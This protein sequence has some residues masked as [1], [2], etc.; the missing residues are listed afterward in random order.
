MQCFLIWQFHLIRQRES[1][2][3]VI[4]VVADE[5]KFFGSDY[6][7]QWS[8]S[9]DIFIFNNDGNIILDRVVSDNEPPKSV[10]EL[11]HIGDD[12][13]IISGGIN[14][15]TV[16]MYIAISSPKKVMTTKIK[17]F[18][19]LF[20]IC[21]LAWI[22]VSVPVIISVI[23]ANYKPIKEMMNILG[24]A[25]KGNE[26]TQIKTYIEDMIGVNQSL[27]KNNEKQYQSLRCD[28]LSKLLTGRFLYS[29]TY[30]MLEKYNVVFDKKDYAVFLFDIQSAERL[31]EEYY[32]MTDE[33][34]YLY[35]KF[36]IFN[37]FE[38]L[39]NADDLSAY[40]TEADNMFACIVNFSDNNLENVKNKA[41][42]GVDFINKNFNIGISYSMSGVH[43]SVEKL[44]KAYREAL[45]VVE[46]KILFEDGG[47]LTY[48][49]IKAG[50]E[51]PDYCFSD[52]IEQKLIS[53]VKTGD[54]ESSAEQIF[55][56]FFCYKGGKEFNA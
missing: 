12:R 34:R 47:N 15:D 53:C 19:T 25:D 29:Y 50:S 37:V 43:E 20:V 36:I 22:F 41:K 55:L 11:K 28:E 42:Y 38:E 5:N 16:K 3:A 17:L 56:C 27:Q 30:K 31:F 39:L 21:L 1:R 7:A 4:S 49:D 24:V 6:G 9:S 33:K 8:N 44:S 54:Y 51:H 18:R 13:V 23:R 40:V 46:Y 26:F 35:V 14:F 45:S 52:E 32:D 2:G 48:D 10:S